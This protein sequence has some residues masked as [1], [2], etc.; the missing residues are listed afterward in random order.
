[1]NVIRITAAAALSA[2]A[3][4]A[5]AAQPQLVGEQDYPVQVAEQ[6]SSTVTRAQVLAELAQAKANGQLSTGEQ[7][8]PVQAA[9]QSG[10]TATRAQVL[11]ELA[12]AKAA[13]LLST[14]EAS[15]P[16]ASI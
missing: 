3:I 16:P 8:Y 14:G 5:H 1:M 2:L 7:D 12:Q 10:S 4:G 6:S 9:E 15:Y 13:G 11:A